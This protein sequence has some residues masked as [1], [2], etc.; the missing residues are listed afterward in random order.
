[1]TPRLFYA[2]WS[3]ALALL[4]LVCTSG[5]AFAQNSPDVPD[6]VQPPD[7]SLQ[8]GTNGPRSSPFDPGEESD[9]RFVVDDA[10]GL[11]TGCTF[12]SGGPL[13]F[14]VEI[15]RYVGEVDG[16]HNLVEPTVLVGND[17]VSATATLTMPA[18]DVD[19]GANVSGIAPERDRVLV[20]GEEVGFLRGSNNTWIQNRLDVPISLLKFPERASNGNTPDPAANRITIEIDVANAPTREAWCTSIDWA[21]IEFKAVSPVIFVHGNDQDPG[22]WNR[23]GFVEELD[24]LRFPYDG[25]GDC[26]NPIQLPTSTIRVNGGTLVQLVPPIVRTFGTDSYHL[27]VHSKG[28]LD[29]RQFLAQQGADA[30]PGAISFT[31]L[32]TP[33]N[34][35]IGA[36][37]QL[38]VEAASEVADRLEY[39][40]FPENIEDAADHLSPN[41]GTP[42]LTTSFVAGFNQQN[43]G[44][45]PG[46]ITYNTIGGDIDRNGSQT[47]DQEVEYDALV[48]EGGWLIGLASQFRPGFVESTMT[49]IYQTLATTADVQVT[50]RQEP[51]FLG[52][53]T[54]TVATLTQ[55]PTNRFIQNDL[56]VPVP[57]ARGDNA[58]AQKVTNNFVYTDPDGRNHADIANREVAQ[59]VMPWIYEV[60]RDSGDLKRATIKRPAL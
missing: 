43:V 4:L 42:N 37:L 32:S 38:E 16:D 11:D 2:A 20:N 13:E 55:V 22:F 58:F 24:A 21:A 15:T 17:I 54:R 50:M 31:S 59:R 46:N 35:S 26:E 7:Y 6:S 57:S 44:Q 9:R 33:H 47:V 48:D 10:P 53:G 3:G 25:C 51:G 14:D 49:A 56:L 18:F 5:P 45:L 1:M 52:F 36:D 19:S 30:E 39:E 29:T 28:G 60:E 40:D 8:K 41:A 23:R 12:R 27:V 34:G